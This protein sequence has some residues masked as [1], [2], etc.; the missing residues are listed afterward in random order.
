MIN[1]KRYMFAKDPFHSEL[2]PCRWGVTRPRVHGGVALIMDKLILTP[3][4]NEVESTLVRFP[5]KPI[6]RKLAI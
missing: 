1:Y 5:A 6:K 3:T 2:S 4:L